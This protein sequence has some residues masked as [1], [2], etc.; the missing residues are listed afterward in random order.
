MLSELQRELARFEKFDNFLALVSSVWV[1]YAI[2]YVAIRGVA[3]AHDLSLFS[4]STLQRW[5]TQTC[6]GQPQYF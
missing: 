5:L 1:L 3:A 6:I 2:G 4:L